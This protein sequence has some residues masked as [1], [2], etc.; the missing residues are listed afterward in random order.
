M[1]S[2]F[3]LEEIGVQVQV[4]PKTPRED[5][6]CLLHQE[7]GERGK[8]AIPGEK[9]NP[10]R[11]LP[12]DILSESIR[13]CLDGIPTIYIA[14]FFFTSNEAHMSSALLKT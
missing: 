9:P 5:R 2:I 11:H 8:R 3:H 1:V 14:F 13:R 12:F 6:M 4:E 7:S 10:P